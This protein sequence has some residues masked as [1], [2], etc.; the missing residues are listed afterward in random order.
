MYIN[1]GTKVWNIEI[2]FVSF[3]K[4]NKKMN[5][6]IMSSKVWSIE[7]QKHTKMFQHH[8]HIGST[9]QFNQLGVHEK[10]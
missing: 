5:L 8:A 10:K 2:N 9:D 3:K 7:I 4:A 6:K 1:C